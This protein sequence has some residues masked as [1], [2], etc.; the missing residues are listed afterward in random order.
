MN[1]DKT[2]KTLKMSELK[3]DWYLI[4]ATDI[5]LGRLAAFAA[6]I[7]RGKNKPTYTPSMDCGD[8]LIIINA[9]KVALT[10]SKADK[11]KFFW[12]T[13]WIGNTKER[14]LGQ[15]RAEKPEV[16]IEN[17]VKRMMGRRRRVALADKRLSHLFVYA[18]ASHKHSAQ[19]PKTIDF[20]AM[21][22]KNKR[23]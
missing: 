2:T 13:G 11:T 20:G 14:T 7:L 12:H 23:A 19:N 4:D 8:N 21:N 6:T 9:D 17:A 5:V 10:G 22:K 3:S 18:G 16:L 1:I 15:M